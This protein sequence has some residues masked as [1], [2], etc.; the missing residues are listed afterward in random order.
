MTPLLTPYN[1]GFNIA[2]ELC[3][4]H[5]AACLS[6]GAHYLSPFGTT[7][8]APRRCLAERMRLAELALHGALKSVQDGET[9]ASCGGAWMHRRHDT[10]T[11][12]LRHGAQ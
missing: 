3:L 5:A 4:D 12:F 8:E 10:T 2:E 9:G 11:L 6:G 7:S 1:N